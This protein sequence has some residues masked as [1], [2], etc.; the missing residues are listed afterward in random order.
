[1]HV[2]KDGRVWNRFYEPRAK[3]RSRN[4]ENNVWIPTLAGERNSRGQEVE[5]GDV[6][7]GGVRSP[8]DHEEVVH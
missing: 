3:Q 4:S 5:L 8:G 1:V 7:T 2:R 6:A